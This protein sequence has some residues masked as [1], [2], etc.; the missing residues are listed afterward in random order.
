MA[1]YIWYKNKMCGPFKD[2][3]EG[4][5]DLWMLMVDNDMVNNPDTPPI[6][7]SMLEHPNDAHVVIEK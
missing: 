5:I 6:N 2:I 3:D 7:K 1:K 4:Q